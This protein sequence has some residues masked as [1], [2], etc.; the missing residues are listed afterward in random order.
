MNSDLETAIKNFRAAAHRYEKPDRYY[1][2]DHD[3]AFTTE[4]FASA[5]GSLFREF[6][7][8][9]CPSICDAVRDKLKIT[10]FSLG[11]QAS[12]P[13]YVARDAASVGSPHVPGPPPEHLRAGWLSKGS[14][15]DQSP[16]VGKEIHK[17]IDSLWSDNRMDLTA[18]EIHLEALKLGDSYAI[19]WPGPEGKVCIY[20]QRAAQS[21]VAYDE[22]IP[23]RMKWAA[24][25]WRDANEHIRLEIFYPDRIEYYISGSKS[26]IALPDFRE[27][28]PFLDP[29]I[30]DPHSAIRNPFG[31]IPL[32]HFANTSEIGAFGRSELAQAIPIQNG[33]NKSVLDMLVA[34]EFSSFRQRWVAGI[35]F[36]M[37]ESGEPSSPFKSGVDR[38]WMSSNPQASFG[39]FNTT[40]LEQFLKVK[41]SFSR[42]YGRR[43]RHTASLL[44][45]KRPRLRQCRGAK[46]RRVPLHRKGPRPP[47]SLRS[48]LEFAHVLR[49]SGR[50]PRFRHPPPYPVGRPGTD[51]RARVSRKHDPQKTPG[52]FHPPASYRIRLRGQRHF[53]NARQSFRTACVNGRPLIQRVSSPHVSKGLIG[54]I[55]NLSNFKFEL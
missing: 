20:P 40:D 32:F 14:S 26:S 22:Q 6:A 41:D 25:Y 4:K 39:D 53:R 52:R 45:S 15:S 28:R 5:F 3:L 49:S 31:R 2:G 23:G 42:R 37:T 18:E 8:N 36:E 13:A 50:G 43:H 51:C 33:L 54:R 47:K 21:T 55:R 27:F 7:L 38:L 16:L 11:T 17:A 10:G 9:L 35:D 48:N 12:L 34:M 44:S 29:E 46:A 19:A 30:R 1:R 24:K